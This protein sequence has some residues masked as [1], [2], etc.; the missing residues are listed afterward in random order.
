MLGVRLNSD[1]EARLASLCEET[2]R[3]K[4]YY[5]KKALETFL[6]DREDYLRGIAILEKK[7]SCVS[8][9]ELEKEIGL[10]S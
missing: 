7:E 6:D 3:T 10:D 4:S 8:L 5:T 9:N 2:G 1:M